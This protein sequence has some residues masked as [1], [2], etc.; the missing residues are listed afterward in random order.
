MAILQAILTTLAVFWTVPAAGAAAQTL[1]VQVEKN[2]SHIK[3]TDATKTLWQQLKESH[4]VTH[5]GPDAEHR[6]SYVGI[7]G[8]VEAALADDPDLEVVIVIHTAT[9]PTPLRTV[10]KNVENPEIAETITNRT[11]VLH[12]YLSVPENKKLFTVYPETAAPEGMD[13]YKNTLELFPSTLID[14]PY[15]GVFPKE[16]TGATYIFKNKAGELMLFGIKA[17]QANEPE[18]KAVWALWFGPLTDPEIQK[19]FQEVNAFLKSVDVKIP[20]PVS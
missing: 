6:P 10:P 14:T 1:T 7:Q 11:K 2:L 4:F 9:P 16:I 15:K 12:R 3:A 17:L 18:E 8:C 5:V 13:V 19:R 20:W